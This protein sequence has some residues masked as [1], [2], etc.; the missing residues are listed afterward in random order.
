M[1]IAQVTGKHYFGQRTPV[2]GRINMRVKWD[3]RDKE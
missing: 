2:C 3:V 1:E